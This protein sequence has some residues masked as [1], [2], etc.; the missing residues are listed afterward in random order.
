MVK[1]TGV[2]NIFITGLVF[3]FF[4]SLFVSHLSLSDSSVV[5]F[6]SFRVFLLFYFSVQ[7]SFSSA[8]VPGQAVSSEIFVFITGLP[9]SCAT[10]PFH[11][12]IRTIHAC[13]SMFCHCR[14]ASVHRAIKS[15]IGSAVILD[16]VLAFYSLCCT[17]SVCP[18]TCTW[19]SFLYLESD[20]VRLQWD[21]DIEIMDSFI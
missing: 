20:S 13:S 21:L 5:T 19:L 1:I 2:L 9:A 14:F 18:T 16:D 11:S 10:C 4:G 7:F 15:S 17:Q 12:D 6:E 8:P 3:F